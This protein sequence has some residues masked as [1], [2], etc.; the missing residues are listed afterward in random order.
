[1]GAASRPYTRIG[2][3]AD[4][5]DVSTRAAAKGADHV[6]HVIVDV[7][8]H[9]RSKSCRV[10]VSAMFAEAGLH[11]EAPAYI[12]GAIRRRRRRAD[13]RRLA[14]VSGGD[15]LQTARRSLPVG[16]PWTKSKCR[17]GRELVIG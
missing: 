17:Q 8:G 16:A 13:G 1:M 2:T 5:L 6:A 12:R 9:D 3:P 14:S 11:T 10:Q 15:R 7:S 4:D